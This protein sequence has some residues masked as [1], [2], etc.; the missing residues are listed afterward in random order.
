M[1]TIG[2]PLFPV[3]E[4]E[5]LAAKVVGKPI[6]VVATMLPRLS[7]Q[8]RVTT[9]QAVSVAL[10]LGAPADVATEIV[11]QHLLKLFVSWP[12]HLGL[13][14]RPLPGNWADDPA[15]V[16]DAVFGPLGEPVSAADFGQFLLSG[17]GV[18]P[19]LRA[20]DRVFEKGEACSAKLP[21]ATPRN[22]WSVAPLENSAAMR[23]VSNPAMLAIEAARGRGPLWRA[24]ARVFDIAAVFDKV[25]PAPY[26]PEPGSAIV[27]T[28]RGIY[29]LQLKS[30]AGVVTAFK[31]VTPT[32]CLLA[33]GGV[34]QQSLASLDVARH[35]LA[36]V[37]LE[38]LDP[39]GPAS[40]RE[41]LEAH[42]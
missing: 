6:G 10:R 22:L 13:G 35:E 16:L 17:H 20:I 29:G 1:K 24:T 42:R 27:S 15:S 33:T 41:L 2:P 8:C 5:A 12:E 23:H 21:L 25:L 37:V 26:S 18:A 34:V 7:P 14:A 28:M 19:V 39:C 9:A 40:L 38:I 32:D 4:S 3:P 31:Q 11:H 30:E 36:P